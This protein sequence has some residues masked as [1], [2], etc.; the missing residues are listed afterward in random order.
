MLRGRRGQAG[1]KS[2]TRWHVSGRHIVNNRPQGVLSSPMF[3]KK[4]VESFVKESLMQTAWLSQP[5]RIRL[6]V[7]A[8]TR[9]LSASSMPRPSLAQ[10][11]QRLQTGAATFRNRALSRAYRW[12]TENPYVYLLSFSLH[13]VSSCQKKTLST[14]KSCGHSHRFKGGEI[15]EQPRRQRSE[16]VVTQVARCWSRGRVTARAK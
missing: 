12:Q 3:T 5:S 1:A 9:T 4:M 10:P 15:P 8:N 14:T 7:A 2:G 6:I 11:R 16:A 13:W